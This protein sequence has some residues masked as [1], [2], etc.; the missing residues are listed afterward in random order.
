MAPST[1]KAALGLGL[2]GGAAFVAPQS[3][4]RSAGTALRGAA[5]QQPQ[6]SSL[7]SALPAV[8]VGAA[9]A[10]LVSNM[11]RKPSAGRAAA[12]VALRAFEQESWVCSPRWATGTPWAW[13]RTGT[14]RPSSGAAPWS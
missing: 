14:S 8:G 7:L 2:L 6:D 11:G 1:S 9:G 3:G 12:A 5:N 13:P 10:L 4:A